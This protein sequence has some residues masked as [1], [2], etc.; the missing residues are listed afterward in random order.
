MCCGCQ[1]H[2]S[3]KWLRCRKRSAGMGLEQVTCSRG[4]S[5]ESQ[6]LEASPFPSLVFLEGGVAKMGGFLL[7]QSGWSFRTSQIYPVLRRISATESRRGKKGSHV[8]RGCVE[9]E[10]L[11]VGHLDF[12]PRQWGEF[13]FLVE[14]TWQRAWLE[15]SI[16]FD[17]QIDII[18]LPST[19]ATRG[20][21]L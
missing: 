16:L 3:N 21:G 20:C 15:S 6:L 8:S 7:F 1:L 13:G 2:S 12:F 17:S 14:A 19:C 4:Q 18:E 11:A 10:H 9:G 5:R